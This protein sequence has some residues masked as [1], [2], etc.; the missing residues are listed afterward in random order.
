MGHG[1]IVGNAGGPYKTLGGA[2]DVHNADVHTIPVNQYFHRLTGV[3]SPLAVAASSQDRDIVVDDATNFNVGDS[4]QINEG[5]TNTTFPII[6]S[7]AVNTLTL[8]RLIDVGIL[9]DTDIKVVAINL[10]INATPG[11]PVIFALTPPPGEIW[12]IT[13]ILPT[14][15]H[16]LGGDLSLFGDL[17]ALANGV[18]I[19]AKVSGQYGTFTNWKRALDIKKDMYDVEFDSRALGTGK[20][21]TSGRG[22]FSRIDVG[23][24]LNGDNGD[25]LEAVIQDNLSTLDNFNLNGQ[26]HIE[27]EAG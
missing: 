20:F 26:G 9:I 6:K 8:D 3:E 2:M 11:A 25:Q 14:L 4:I 21:G 24:R 15:T 16:S 18:I 22:S 23:V 27:G 17:A 13:R 5:I 12:H 7:I 1:D 10:G 19:R